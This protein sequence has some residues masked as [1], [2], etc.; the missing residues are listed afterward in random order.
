MAGH[1]GGAWKVAYAD[2]VTAMMAFF[3][4]MWI[5]AQSKPVKQAIS[6]YFN[7]PGRRRR[8]RR[9]TPRGDRPCCRRRSRTR[10][11]GRR[12][13]R[14]GSPARWASERARPGPRINGRPAAA[15]EGC[16]DPADSATA[17]AE[18][19][20]PLRP[21]RRRRG[22][23]G[24]AGSL[25]RGRER[26]GRSEQA[27]AEALGPGHSR[28]A[29]QDRDSRARDA[30]VFVARRGAGRVAAFLRALFGDDEFLCSS[31]ASPRSGFASVKAAPTSPTRST[32]RRRS[33]PTIPASRSTCS[34][35]TR[36]S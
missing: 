36:K 3:L 27:T 13:R 18:P 9:A 19:I 33:R 17:G 24:D 32:R 12:W 28:Q 31:R 2:F 5:T 21:P 26:I 8:N 7:D 22:V 15:V 20:D 16:A 1:G 11:R 10:R 35:A 30:E 23:R 6:Q 14:R 29:V 25:R 4:V 34:A